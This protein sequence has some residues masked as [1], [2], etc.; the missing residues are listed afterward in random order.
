MKFRYVLVKKNVKLVTAFMKNI[1]L[2]DYFKN[3]Y[4]NFSIILKMYLITFIFQW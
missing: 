1:L 2:I 4:P 3:S